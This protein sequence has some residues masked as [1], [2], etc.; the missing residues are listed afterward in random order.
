MDTKNQ[1]TKNPEVES[2][3]PEAVPEAVEEK[4]LEER[5]TEA[6]STVY[7]PEIPVDIY[8]LGLI[9]GVE[10]GE[11]GHVD[12]KMTLTSPSCPAAGILPGEVEMKVKGVEGV[13]SAEVEIV[14]DPVWNPSMMSEAAQLELGM[15]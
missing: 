3:M 12:V 15:F 11:E 9:Y 4:S 7:D 13:V 6:I 8:A 10:V 14:W 2:T 1:E 5:I